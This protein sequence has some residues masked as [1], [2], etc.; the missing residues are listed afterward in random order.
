[1]TAFST[2]TLRLACDLGRVDAALDVRTNLPPAALRGADVLFQ[3]AAFRDGAIVAA[4][5]EFATVS[6][7]VRALAADGSPGAQQFVATSAALGACTA[8]DWL[9]GLDQHAQIAVTAAQLD[10][11]AGRY[12]VLVY[13]VTPGGARFPWAHAFFTI[14]DAGLAESDPPDDPASDYYTDAEMLAR[15]LGAGLDSATCKRRLDPIAA[16]AE[17]LAVVFTTP[18][19]AAPSNLLPR[20]RMPSSSGR[21]I[22]CVIDHSTVTAAGFTVRFSGPTSDAL[23]QL[24]WLALL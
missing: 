10:L 4:E 20:V 3:L 7:I 14:I 21:T 2:K 22:L 5:A 6:L 19:A 15:F 23:H 11:A 12:R 24:D 8:A 13:G 17:S 18:F 16:G 1:M 9:A